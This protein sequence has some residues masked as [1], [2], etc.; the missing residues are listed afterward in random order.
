MTEEV[1]AALRE[2]TLRDVYESLRDNV[3]EN[4]NDV[5]EH[6]SLNGVELR[7]L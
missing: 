5:L 2:K 1:F 6:D 4:D 7:L 3:D